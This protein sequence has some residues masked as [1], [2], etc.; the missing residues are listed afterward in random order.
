MSA[1]TNYPDVTVALTPHGVP[2]TTTS[3][4]ANTDLCCPA[5]LQAR[6]AKEKKGESQDPT[7]AF[8][9][10]CITPGTPFMAR[11]QAHLSFFIRKKILE[12]P[13]WQKPKVILS[14]DASASHAGDFRP[15]V[16]MPQ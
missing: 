9:S 7:T 2:V 11:L 6:A 12:D 16:H 10:N 5:W 14:G 8:D 3:F 4:Q 15:L 1:S 13:A